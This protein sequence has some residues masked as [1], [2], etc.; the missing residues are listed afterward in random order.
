MWD[1]TWSKIDR[2]AGNRT[3]KC[4]A[5]HFICFGRIVRKIA[6]H[7]LTFFQRTPTWTAGSTDQAIIV[8]CETNPCM[9]DPAAYS[10][11]I[12]VTNLVNCVAEWIKASFLRRNWSH[13]G[14]SNLTLVTLLRHWI[15]RF[16]MIISAWWLRTSSKFSGQEFEEIHKNLGS[17]ETPKQV[18][19]VQ[20]L[21]P[22]AVGWRE[23]KLNMHNNN[24]TNTSVTSSRQ[25]SVNYM[26]FMAIWFLWRNNVCKWAVAN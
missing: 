16:T 3:L 22:G 1:Q 8:S 26:V 17:L 21:A 13:D 11:R 6:L 23:D 5:I 4:I 24:L 14:G 10:S 20:Q 7:L 15:R 19:I 2:T 25:Y 9:S 18:R 12:V